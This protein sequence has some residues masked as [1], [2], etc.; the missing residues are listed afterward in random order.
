MLHLRK[1]EEIE[2]AAQKVIS[3][4]NE[5]EQF[6]E[7]LRKSKEI[8]KKFKQEQETLL[9]H[10]QDKKMVLSLININKRPMQAEH[11]SIKE[12]LPVLPVRFPSK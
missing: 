5:H 11:K 3:H 1:I 12:K 6:I 2:R 4:K 8:A 7:Q 9:R 10:Q